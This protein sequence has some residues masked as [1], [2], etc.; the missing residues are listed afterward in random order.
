MKPNPVT[1]VI[2]PTLKEVGDALSR[3]FK[4]YPV[5]NLSGQL[6]GSISANFLIV[7]IQNGAWYTGGG[8]E[9]PSRGGELEEEAGATTGAPSITR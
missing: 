5:T 2:V 8:P 1:L 6:V 9:S 4:S 3:G 7:I